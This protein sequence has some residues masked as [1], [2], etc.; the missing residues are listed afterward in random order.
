MS[1]AYVLQFLCEGMLD[2]VAAA[3]RAEGIPYVRI[4]GR[5]SARARKEALAA[6]SSSAPDS[7]RLMLASLK[8]GGVGMN[9]VAGSHVH[10]MDP[11]WNPAV[12]DQAMVSRGEEEACGGVQWGEVL[13]RWSL[14]GCKDGGRQGKGA[15]G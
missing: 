12:E 4:D 14:L 2:L 15:A 11:W 7:P 5:S 1:Y 10:L 6:F 9:L 8:A 13:D 3:V